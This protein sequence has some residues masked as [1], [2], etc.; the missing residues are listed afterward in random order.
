L[1]LPSLDFNLSAA[2]ENSSKVKSVGLAV[3]FAQRLFDAYS[4]ETEN[5]IEA[6]KIKFRQIL[7]L[8]NL[9]SL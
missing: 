7:V 3:T 8:I 4:S 2:A 1:V 5:C 9:D 6:C